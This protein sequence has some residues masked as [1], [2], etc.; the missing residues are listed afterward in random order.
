[1]WGFL[2]PR[3]PLPLDL[4]M[5]SAGGV[6]QDFTCQGSGS[7]VALPLFSSLVRNFLCKQ[8]SLGLMYFTNLSA[9]FNW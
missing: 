4:C 9:S 6:T 2:P 1:M 3:A 7:L 5:T 8:H